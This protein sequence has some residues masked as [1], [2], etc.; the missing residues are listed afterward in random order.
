MIVTLAAKPRKESVIY[1]EDMGPP[2]DGVLPQF[3][4]VC[5]GQ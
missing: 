5:A 2:T 3:V 4:S 1:S